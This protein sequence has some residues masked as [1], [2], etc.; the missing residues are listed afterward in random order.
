MHSRSFLLVVMCA[1]AAG[2]A[3][4]AEDPKE[5]LASRSTFRFVDTPLVDLKAFLEDVHNIRID[6]AEGVQQSHPV[7]M[8]FDGRLDKG[9][10]QVLESFELTFVV[11]EDRIVVAPIDEREYKELCETLKKQHAE[12][13]EMEAAAIA[14]LSKKKSADIRKSDYYGW[15]VRVVL[16]GDD[17]ADGDLQHLQS[18]RHVQT[19]ALGDTKVTDDGMRHL[20]GLPLC[21]LILWGGHITDVGLVRL[22]TLKHLVFLNVKNTMVSEE[23]LAALKKAIPNLRIIRPEQD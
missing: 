15:V 3:G 23:G 11:K 2:S 10:A 21:Q 5:A 13:L 19:L 20:Q 16:Q 22:Q 6:L 9:L 18:L 4:A 8:H 14:A 7:T 1:F 12:A 17:V